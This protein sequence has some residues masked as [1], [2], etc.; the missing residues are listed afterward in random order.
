[1]DLDDQAQ[2]R[3]EQAAEAVREYKGTDASNAVIR[4][5]DAMADHYRHQL[6]EADVDRVVVLQTQVK[7]VR[8]LIRVMRGEPYV[9]PAN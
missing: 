9:S 7:Q 4:M 8:A 3:M 1:M 5:L 2:K 6:V